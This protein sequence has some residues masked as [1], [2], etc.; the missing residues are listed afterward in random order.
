MLCNGHLGQKVCKN[1]TAA[2]AASKVTTMAWLLHPAPAN[3][4]KRETEI[5]WVGLRSVHIV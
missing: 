5:Q 3:A 4:E 1:P 2:P